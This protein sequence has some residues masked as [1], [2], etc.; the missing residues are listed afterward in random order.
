MKL[1]ETL[2]GNAKIKETLAADIE[3]GTQSHAYIIEGAE[4]SGK[5]TAATLAVMSLFCKRDGDSLPCLSCPS[6]KKHLR[7][8]L[9]T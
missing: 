1:F 9:P 4:G 2:A 6:C 5:H 8:L 3:K 7:V